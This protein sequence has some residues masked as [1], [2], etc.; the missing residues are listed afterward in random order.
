MEQGGGAAEGSTCFMVIVQALKEV[1]WT[2]LLGEDVK[3]GVGVLQKF[4]SRANLAQRLWKN[5][6]S[7]SNKESRLLAQEAAEEMVDR[8]DLADDD[9][10]DE[11]E[12]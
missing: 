7:P 11:Q 2:E 6:K 9:E 3:V 8:V 5:K 12:L 10:E 4:N 1:D